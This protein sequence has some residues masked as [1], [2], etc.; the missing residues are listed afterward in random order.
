ML[1]KR[2]I[3]LAPAGIQVSLQ[4]ATPPDESLVPN[5]PELNHL[6]CEAPAG[7]PRAVIRNIIG[8]ESIA[9]PPRAPPEITIAQ[10]GKRKASP[11]WPP[12]SS[13]PQKEA[14]KPAEKIGMAEPLAKRARRTDSSAMWEQTERPRRDTR[15]GTPRTDRERSAAEDGRRGDRDGDRRHRSRSRDRHDRKRERSRERDRPTDRRDG[16]D[17]RDRRWE[18]SLS[19]DRRRGRRD[20]PRARSRSPLR[21]GGR[22]RERE[23]DGMR[24]RSPPRGSRRGPSPARGRNGVDKAPSKPT[25]S[26]PSS[27]TPAPSKSSTVKADGME[28]DTAAG[29]EDELEAAMRKTM[30]FASF[31]ST[32]NTKVPGNDKLYGVRKEKQMEARQYMNRTGGFNRPLSPS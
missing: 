25:S 15:D 22:D 23:R 16:R 26:Q 32:K 3:K 17:G 5:A 12:A 18:R 28:I 8:E 27:K 19:R 6:P 13:F 9:P 29:T 7:P 14:L 2:A 24:N 11:P 30:G 20:D 1:R 10:L 21:D 4:V 31:R